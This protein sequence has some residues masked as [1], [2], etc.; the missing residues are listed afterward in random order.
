MF[1]ILFDVCKCDIFMCFEM[2]SEFV[3]CIFFLG[4]ECFVRDC[5][6][7]L[8]LICDVKIFRWECSE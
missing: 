2:C 3:E 6:G 7:C 4:V 1:H 5:M 8:C